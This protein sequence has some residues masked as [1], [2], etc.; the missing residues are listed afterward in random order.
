[1]WKRPNNDDWVSQGLTGP[2]KRTILIHRPRWVPW[3]HLS[4]CYPMCCPF[5]SRRTTERLLDATFLLPL[6]TVIC[7]DPHP[8]SRS[9][10]VWCAVPTGFQVTPHLSVCWGGRTLTPCH[11]E[12]CPHYPI[13]IQAHTDFSISAKPLIR[14]GYISCL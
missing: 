5:W 8:G 2:G 4:F 1:M 11:L 13:H 9:R 10:S 12:T 7:G 3:L 6:T 14:L